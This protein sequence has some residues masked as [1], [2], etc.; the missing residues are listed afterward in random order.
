LFV[1]DKPYPN[2]E[3]ASRNLKDIGMIRSEG[4]NVYDL[5]NHGHVVLLEPAVRMIE[6]ALLS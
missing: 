2:L 3:R 4:I 6:G 1:L 5:L